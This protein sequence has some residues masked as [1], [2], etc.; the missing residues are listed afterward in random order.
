[1]KKLFFGI[2]GIGALIITAC[3]NESNKNDHEGH[4]MSKDTT[5]HSTASDNKDVK[6][7][8][9]IYNNVD[10]KA[11]ASI[12]EIVDHYL[13]VKNALANDNGNEAAS[14]AKAMGKA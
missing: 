13:H 3:S 9:V 6:V 1:M 4:D 8:P 10:A 7:V 14:G 11:A 2:L 12:K 5:Q